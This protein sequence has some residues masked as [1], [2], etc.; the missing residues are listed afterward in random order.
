MSESPNNTPQAP[1]P[2]RPAGE[3]GGGGFNWRVLALFGVA[4]LILGV[5]I[6][7]GDDTKAT[8]ISYSEFRTALDQGR[9]AH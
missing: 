4:I 2:N 9:V 6:F 5:G 1:K 7:V 3:G 8:K